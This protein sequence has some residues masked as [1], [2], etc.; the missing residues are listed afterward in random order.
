M[1]YLNDIK[2]TKIYNKEA[3][4]INL[5]FQVNDIWETAGNR[6]TIQLE[7]EPLFGLKA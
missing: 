5:L 3:K 6:G 2:F 1:S 7:R 4:L